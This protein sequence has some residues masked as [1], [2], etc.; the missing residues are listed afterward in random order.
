MTKNEFKKFTSNRIVVLCGATGINLIKA[1]MPRG[2]CPERWILDNPESIISLHQ[3]YIEAGSEIIYAPT[4]TA[5]RIK[6]AE[7]GL[8]SQIAELNTE[9]VKL[10]LKTSDGKALVA[11]DITM[12]GK[13]LKPHGELEFE[14][15]ID[16]YKEQIGYLAEA[17]ADLLVVETMT[18]LAETRAALIA[19]SEVCDLPVMATLS[20]EADERT[21]YGSDAKTVAVVLKSLGADAIGVNCA[22]GPDRMAGII[23]DMAAVTDIPIIA[24]PNAG[25]PILDADG[26]T[27][28]DMTEAVFAGHMQ[29]LIEAGASLI[30]GCCGTTPS[31]I[32]ELKEKFAKMTPK[33]REMTEIRHISSERKTVSFG[34]TDP[35]IIV[36]ER[37]NPT[38]KKKL[39]EELKQGL[40]GMVC[41]FA[42]EQETAGAKI[43]D[44]NMGM[45]GINEKEMMLK[46]ITE[47]SA[48]T[49]LPLAIDSSHPEVIE[50][51]LRNYPGRALI[52]SI[53][54]EKTKFNE[55]LP[56]AKK[57]GAMFILLPLS[58]AGLPANIE[59][60]IAIIEKISAHAI[61]MGIAQQDIIVDALVT[62]VGANKNAAVETLETIR[63]CK[64][65]G[66]AT[67]CGL[68]NISFGLP[69]RG[70][71]NATFLTMAINAG[72]TMAIANP[73]H[74]LMV[75]SA[76]ASDMLMNRDGADMKYI[77]QMSQSKDRKSVV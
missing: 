16:V 27:I 2:V 69:E 76:L 51:A 31:F 52:N 37:I 15:L 34:L 32:R 6:L 4:F 35:F 14:E 70:F 40:M 11:G 30:G 3:R 48:T 28:Y 44:V 66:Y 62:S 33:K 10:A 57:Y 63:Y 75:N 49:S 72:L 74:E 23:R 38:G 56:I 19:A 59:E 13:L 1:G 60:K 53:S 20:F 25:M 43:L 55:I 58:D 68:S 22:T 9:L 5:N 26:Q 45:E 18:S 39:K 7:Y 24:K 17:G 64:E 21:L 73:N 47:I 54:L 50:A 71:V 36:G 77:D 65:K 46:A 41:D 8:E 29:S 42:E 12:T 67:I 61:E